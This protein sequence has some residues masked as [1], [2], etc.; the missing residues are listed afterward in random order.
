MQGSKSAY[1]GCFIGSLTRLNQVRN[2]NG[3]HNEND[4]DDD[5]QLDQRKAFL[6]VCHLR[7]R[8][9]CSLIAITGSSLAAPPGLY[10]PPG[11][12]RAPF[13]LCSYPVNMH[14]GG[15]SPRFAWKP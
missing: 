6:L 5:Q 8:S 13:V 7:L 14:I 2:S 12:C 11:T 15:H 3:S 4:G 9:C 10:P 1:R